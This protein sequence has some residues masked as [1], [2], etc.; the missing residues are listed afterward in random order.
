MLK[1]ET[2]YFMHS[3]IAL[4]SSLTSIQILKVLSSCQYSRLFGSNRIIYEQL[5]HV[6]FADIILDG[7]K[8]KTNCF[9]GQ[10]NKLKLL[11]QPDAQLRER[12]QEH[13]VFY[14]PLGTSILVQVDFLISF[15]R[16][17]AQPLVGLGLL[18]A[19]KGPRLKTA[20]LRKDQKCWIYKE[21]LPKFMVQHRNFEQYLR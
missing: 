11:H 17:C 8:N 6:H 14:R 7:Q 18:G 12:Q 15:M 2:S 10:L 3:I 21:E 9:S 13:G 19:Q 5:Q 16:A 20:T 1:L 4:S